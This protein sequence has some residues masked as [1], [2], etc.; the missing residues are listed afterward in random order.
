MKE[1][2]KNE[3]KEFK[4]STNKKKV[5]DTDMEVEVEELPEKDKG[6]K[7]LLHPEEK[8]AINTA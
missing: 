1:E 5:G 4:I 7:Y 6:T 3:G 8:V 2:K